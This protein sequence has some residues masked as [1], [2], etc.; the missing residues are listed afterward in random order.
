MLKPFEI[1]RNKNI[2]TCQV[3]LENGFWW[4]NWSINPSKS[5]SDSLYS[6]QQRIDIPIL[7]NPSITVESQ[8]RL[9]SC[10]KKQ[11][12]FLHGGQ[13]DRISWTCEWAYHR[14]RQ[15]EKKK[16]KFRQQKIKKRKHLGEKWGFSNQKT[17]FRPPFEHPKG[18]Q[19]E[20]SLWRSLALGNN[21]ERHNK[22]ETKLQIFPRI[23]WDINR[24]SWKTRSG[25]RWS[26]PF[27]RE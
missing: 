4:R 25:K 11:M 16:R 21:R 22:N 23:K 19:M 8:L 18:I 15:E 26:P 10:S 2:F 24:W 27:Q 17:A 7:L 12:G 5:Y 9:S 20:D 13:S 1:W 6:E 14:I 3:Q